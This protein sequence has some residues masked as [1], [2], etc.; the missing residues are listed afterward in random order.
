MMETLPIRLNPGQ[1]LRRALEA[2]VAAQGCRAGFVIAGIGS[3]VQARLRL[4]GVPNPRLIKGA[5]EIVTLAGSIAVNGSHLH[6]TLTT[7]SGK[8]MGGHLA[9]GCTVRTTAE[10]LLALLRE[11]E[12]KREP[13]SLTG[14]DELSV[15]RLAG[16]DP[17]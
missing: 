9:Y 15:Q 16:Q 5:T 3:L 14:F 10:V 11:W 2:A 1:D 7:S 6:A 13:D 12:F 8:V 4:A 17:T